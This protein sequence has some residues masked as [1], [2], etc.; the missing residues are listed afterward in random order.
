MDKKASLSLS[1]NA[2][3]VLILAITMLGLAL[4]FVNTL[5]SKTSS[6]IEALAQ[7]EQPPV[8]ATPGEPLTLSRYD[9]I[10]RPSET[11]ALKFKVYNIW[12]NPITDKELIDATIGCFTGA[13][14]LTAVQQIKK[15][16]VSD[17]MGESQMLITAKRST[18]NKICSICLDEKL[19]GTN[20]LKGSECVDIH[21]TI[22]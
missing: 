13:D 16:M 17:R 9:I 10:L 6:Q 3:V 19:D 2:I 12:A 1:V 14:P 21:V 20:P 11:T 18:G 15:T 4:S 8:D 5:F 22:K 7:T